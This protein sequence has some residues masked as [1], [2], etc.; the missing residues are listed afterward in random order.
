MPSRSKSS[1]HDGLRRRGAM[2]DREA[3]TQ[4]A[5]VCRHTGAA[6]DAASRRPA[7]PDGTS[8]IVNRALNQGEMLADAVRDGFHLER[9][10]GDV[11]EEFLGRPALALAPE[12]PKQ[13]SGLAACEPRIAELLT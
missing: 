3:R 1:V 7:R 4:D 13:R 5:L 12:L 10:A 9:R 11:L 8:V 6:E 2:G